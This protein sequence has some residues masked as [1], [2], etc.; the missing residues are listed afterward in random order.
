MTQ[1]EL[2][3]ARTNPEFLG[4]LTKREEE[5]LS[6]KKIAGLYEVL[7][8]LLIL[9]LQEDRINKVYETILMVAFDT[10]EERLKDDVK[11]TL[12]GDDIYYIRAFYEHAIE[13]WSHNDFKG[14][15]ELFFILTQIVDDEL[16]VNALYIKMIA[17]NFSEDMDK[18]YDDKV[19][20]QQ[21]ARDERYG[22]FLLDF[23][24][25]SKEYVEL[26]QDVIDAIYEDLKH[27]LGV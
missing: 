26:H 13:K 24:F 7:D 11:L 3:E 5:V 8:S 23:K 21:I 9:D 27:L 16:L 20:H 4:Y 18:F 17:C 12:N 6:E 19:E 14:A 15:K 25:D 2:N 22:Y 1:D 10:I